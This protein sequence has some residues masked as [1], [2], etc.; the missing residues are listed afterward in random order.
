MKLKRSEWAKTPYAKTSA[1]DP[2]GAIT[3]LLNKYD[4]EDVQWTESKGMSGRPA[5]MLR[6]VH[7]DKTYRIM[8]EVLDAEA[9]R[10]ELLR[11]A[12]RAV[13][14][15]LKSILEVTSLFFPAEMALFPHLEI[16]NG[17][18]IYEGLKDKLPKLGTDGFEPLLALGYQGEQS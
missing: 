16:P 8:L 11:Q 7:K 10:D 14:Y 9:S 15:Y 4:I 12:R 5:I 6:F 2:Q 18:T 17:Q 13:Y 1:K 3:S